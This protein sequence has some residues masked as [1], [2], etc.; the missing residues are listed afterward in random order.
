L[1]Y[2]SPMIAISR[3]SINTMTKKA[4]SRNIATAA[5]FV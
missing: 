2:A 3:L 1:E 4:K 5:R